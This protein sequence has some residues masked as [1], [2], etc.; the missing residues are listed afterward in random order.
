[1][2]ELVPQAKIEAIA[3]LGHLAHE[4]APDR[5]AALIVKAVTQSDTIAAQ[6]EMST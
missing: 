6:H 1:V 5:V 4:E 3:G 2:R